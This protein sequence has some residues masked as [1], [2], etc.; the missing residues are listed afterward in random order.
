[1]SYKNQFLN[2][3]IVFLAVFILMLALLS[4]CTSN[5]PE[6]NNFD[7]GNENQQPIANQFQGGREKQEPGGIKGGL[8]MTK[9]TGHKWALIYTHATRSA[10]LKVSIVS[11]DEDRYSLTDIHYNCSYIF[12]QTSP[13]PTGSGIV[14]ELNSI[15]GNIADCYSRS[16][17]N[18]QNNSVPA[19][20]LYPS[21]QFEVIGEWEKSGRGAIARHES[22]DYLIDNDVLILTADS[23][24]GGGNRQI[25]SQSK[26]F[27]S[28]LKGPFHAASNFEFWQSLYQSP[29]GKMSYVEH[30]VWDSSGNVTDVTPKNEVGPNLMRIVLAPT[31]MLIDPPEGFILKT[32]IIDPKNFGSGNGG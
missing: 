21:V 24:A 29:Q 6:E 5:A 2:Y 15:Q 25:Q 18:P 28:S 10:E 20:E 11:W 31:E 22:F 9:V 27:S 14:L 8:Q 23:P 19:V 17:Y 13:S 26:P 30:Y 3:R 7:F 4:A 32:L 16:P 12:D 1:M